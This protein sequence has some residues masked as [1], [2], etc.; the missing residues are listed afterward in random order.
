M[1]KYYLWNKNYNKNLTIMI[2][3]LNSVIKLFFIKYY[4]H[5][6]YISIL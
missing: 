4:N 3:V 5:I 6:F 1:L 2:I